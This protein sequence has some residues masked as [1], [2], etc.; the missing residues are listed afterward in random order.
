MQILMPLTSFAIVTY[1]TNQSMFFSTKF[2]TTD[3][4]YLIEKIKIIKSKPYFSIDKLKNHRHL[5]QIDQRQC[6]AD[7]FHYN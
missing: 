3:S 5:H 1:F 7:R 4:D 6:L 2:I